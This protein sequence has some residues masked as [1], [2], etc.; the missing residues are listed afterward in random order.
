[1]T[2]EEITKTDP[3]QKALNKGL[4]VAFINRHSAY[5]LDVRTSF[6]YY[7][8]DKD[9]VIATSIEIGGPGGEAAFEKLNIKYWSK[10]IV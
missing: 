8:A 2:L 7:D 6:V 4:M 1:M 10:G 5:H 3:M 9:F